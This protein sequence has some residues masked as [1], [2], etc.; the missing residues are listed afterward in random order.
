MTDVLT[1][2]FGST[3]VDRF[4]TLET[5]HS[6][7]YGGSKETDDD[8]RNRFGEDVDLALEGD[9]DQLINSE[10]YPVTGDLA[11]IIMLD[12]YSRN[13]FRGSAR[14]FAGDEKGMQVATGVLASD[15]WQLAKDTL[16]VPQLM[17]F[18]LPLMHQESLDH[19]D[20]CV[21]KITE[22]IEDSKAAGEEAGNVAKLAEQ[23]LAFAQ[24]HHDIIKKFGRYP[25]RNQA[26]GRMCTPEE[27]DFVENGPS[28][29]Q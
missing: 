9:W 12:Q 24:K 10:Q 15:R 26:L 17:F 18:L 6:L 29:G 25:Y 7:W 14:A 22:L 19:L 23:S 16:S 4:D 3:K 5:Q 11:L 28:F 8:I 27:L 13:I 20:M 1:H 21:D 2:W